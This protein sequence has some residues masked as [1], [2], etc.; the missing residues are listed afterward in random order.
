MQ[1]PFV[2]YPSWIRSLIATSEQFKR[3]EAGSCKLLRPWGFQSR[4]CINIGYSHVTPVGFPLQWCDPLLS[5]PRQYATLDSNFLQLCLARV[6]WETHLWAVWKV[7]SCALQ[8]F[9]DRGEWFFHWTKATGKWLLNGSYFLAT[10]I[11]ESFTSLFL[12]FF[13][14]GLCMVSQ[15]FATAIHGNLSHVTSPEY[16]SDTIRMRI[17]VGLAVVLIFVPSAMMNR[18]RSQTAISHLP[19]AHPVYLPSGC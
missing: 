19:V 12:L 13:L 7:H 15:R 17:F 2:A 9:R 18:F 16:P 10:L 6:R 11:G 5:H 3:S 8:F 14:Y 1:L 4:W